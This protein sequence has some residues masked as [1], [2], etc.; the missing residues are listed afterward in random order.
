VLLNPA[1]QHRDLVLPINA[2]QDS[3]LGQV[4]GQRTLGD[5][6]TACG[7]SEG[8]RSALAFFQQLWW[9]DQIVF[10]ASGAVAVE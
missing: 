8:A 2:A 4:D 3:L 7:S 5:I 9:Y 6:V 1:H 10:D